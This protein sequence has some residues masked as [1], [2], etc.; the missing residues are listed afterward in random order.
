MQSLDENNIKQIENFA[1]KFEKIHNELQI[2]YKE[3]LSLKVVDSIK[4]EYE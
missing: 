3:I 2:G 4:Q 1:E